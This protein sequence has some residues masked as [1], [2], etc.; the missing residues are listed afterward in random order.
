MQLSGQNCGERKNTSLHLAVLNS[1]EEMV[2]MLINNGIDIN[3]KNI[4]GQTAL[5][6]AEMRGYKKIIRILK[7]Q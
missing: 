4:Y 7:K 5:G 1:N 6:T 3:K 2:H